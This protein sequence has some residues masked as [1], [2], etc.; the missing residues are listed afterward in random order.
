MANKT[1]TTGFYHKKIKQNVYYRDEEAHE[2]LNGLQSE[3]RIIDGQQI[4]TSSE[5]G[6]LNVFEFTKKDGTKAQFV[7]KNGGKGSDG[8]VAN[9][10]TEGSGNVVTNVELDPA[11]NGL[12]VTKG[13]TMPTT[14]PANGGNADTVDNYHFVVGSSAGTAA[15]T[16]YFVV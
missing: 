10:S 12:K 2:E 13:A 7:V 15:N 4:A 14:L 6:G 3:N 1:Y 16:I 8:S 11:T 9:C 5:D